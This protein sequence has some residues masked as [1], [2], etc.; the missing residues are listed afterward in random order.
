MG[1]V[2]GTSKIIQ[3]SERIVTN[4]HGEVLRDERERV[5][6]LP[7]E[8]EY[9]K[10]Y[11]QDLATVL[12]VPVGPQALLISLVR[13]ID[14]EG[15][16]SLSP[17]SR[18][19]L[20]MQLGIKMHTLANYLTVLCERGILRRVGRGEYEMDPHIMAKGDWSSINKRRNDF[21]MTV[22]YSVDGSKKVTGGEVNRQEE[23]SMELETLKRVTGGE[24]KKQEEISVELETLPGVQA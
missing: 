8:P 18:E 3:I 13:K 22:V 23:I 12:D 1:K 7:Q 15:L 5:L 14:W 20:A 9:V 21:F 24:V 17:S 19:R 10:L 6:R 16:I 2:S 4:E 11:L